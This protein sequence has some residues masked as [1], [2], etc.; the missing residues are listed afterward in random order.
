LLRQAA[1]SSKVV[2]LP[3]VETWKVAGGKLLWLPNGSLLWRWS[4]GTVE[5]L[6]LLLLRLLPLELPWLE[7][8]AMAPILLLLW[9]TQLTPGGVYTMQYLGGA[10]LELPL[11][12]DPG[13]HHPF[14]VDGCTCQL[15][16]RQTREMYQALLQMDGEPRTV[17]VCLLFICVNVV[18]AI[19]SQGVELPRVV[20]Y[21]V[22]LLLKVQELLQLAVEQTHR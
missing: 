22:V 3:T 17:Q 14:L 4:R 9:S 13:L 5:L 6:L 20:E 7:F 15:I 2:H 21:T 18:G 16:V 19:L 8:W 1:L 12:M 11:S 10:P